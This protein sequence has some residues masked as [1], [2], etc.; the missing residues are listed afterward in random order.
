MQIVGQVQELTDKLYEVLKW[1][2]ASSH[3]DNPKG[4]IAEFLRAFSYVRETDVEVE[5]GYTDREGSFRETDIMARGV[6]FEVKKDAKDLGTDKPNDA[7]TQIKRRLDIFRAESVGWATNGE[8]W[9]RYV[10][11]GE[12]KKTK[13]FNIISHPDNRITAD[14]RN[15]INTLESD[16]KPRPAPTGK[17]IIDI[18]TPVQRQVAEFSKKAQKY[19]SYQVKFDLWQ[20]QLNGAHMKKH[21]GEEGRTLFVNHTLLTAAA[22]L[23]AAE[24]AQDAATDILARI[25]TGGGFSTWLDW[26]GEEQDLREEGKKICSAIYQAVIHYDWGKASE[27]ILKHLYHEFIP[28]KERH[29]FGEYYTPDWLAEMVTEK[30]LD[31]NYCKQALKAAFANEDLTGLGVL[32]PA[33]GSGT[34]LFSAAKRF[35]FF[36]KDLKKNDLEISNAI[37]KLIYG[38]D[39]HPVAVELARATLLGILPAR[40]THPLQIYL[41]DALQMNIKQRMHLYDKEGLW[42]EIPKTHDVVIFPKETLEREGFDLIVNFIAGSKAR[43]DQIDL[44]LKGQE[45]SEG[46]AIYLR[47]VAQIL[48]KLRNEGRNG[49]WEW[50]INNLAQPYRLSEKKVGRLIGNPPWITHKHWKND[51]QEKLKSLSQEV[52]VWH[53]G[54]YA[55]QND[56]AAL[57]TVR[58]IQL[59][60]VG[61]ERKKIGCFGFV[62][63]GSA[64]KSEAWKNFRNVTWGGADLSQTSPWKIETKPS[65]FPQ[66]KACVIFGRSGESSAL[67]NP[68]RMHGNWDNPSF[69]EI[70]IYRNEPSEFWLDHQKKNVI[71]QGA[72]LTPIS[73]VRVNK[74]HIKKSQRGIVYVKTY[75]SV[76]EPWKSM[77][78]Q[79][80]ELEENALL[81]ALWGDGLLPF[82]IIDIDRLI[83]PPSVYS[84]INPHKKTFHLPMYWG[85]A[86]SIWKNNR[87]PN[88]PE[89]LEERIDFVGNLSSQIDSSKYKVIYNKSGSHM[90]A[91]VVN[92]DNIIISHQL[93]RVETKNLDEAYYLT[94]ILNCDILKNAFLDC[95]HTDRDFTTFHFQKIPIKRFDSDNEYHNTLAALGK[96]AEQEAAK[97]SINEQQTTKSREQ[98]RNALRASKTMLKIDAAVKAILP[99]YC[100]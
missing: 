15:L 80:G 18:F 90:V 13:V 32:D 45:I 39:I 51:R 89:T 4:A 10:W 5:G 74:K 96:K 84:K 97:V 60:L 3:E 24:L 93:Y 99:D 77:G 55:P 31:E 7:G 70:K 98:I 85:K 69:S 61:Y 16:L 53:G 48:Q 37:A 23:I 83:A 35:L 57:F 14:I 54:K 38:F 34:F 75:K 62:L 12:T 52:N 49:I 91:A 95:C 11:Q 42:L 25:T 1:V 76:H 86:S 28:K 67:A 58:V 41:G 33:C 65:P 88:S 63:P 79:E 66:S 82:R 8:R 94:A 6:A 17:A 27:D 81:V 72:S 30:V 56:L 92:G 87:K 20:E 2:K 29:D 78:Q 71:R 43:E 19:K 21:E 36:A 22:R 100:D 44:I 64:L 40:P 68:I 50:F 46:E 59:Y 9:I 26:E 73:L 47:K